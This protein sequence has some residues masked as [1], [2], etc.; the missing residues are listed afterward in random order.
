MTTLRLLAAAALLAAAGRAAA[1][2]DGPARDLSACYPAADPSRV[3]CY[4][5]PTP[6]GFLLGVPGT[7]AGLARDAVRPENLPWMAGIAVSTAGLLATDER[8]RAGAQ[9]IGRW[10]GISPDGKTA[11]LTSWFP[12]PYPTDVGSGLYYI[13]DGMVPVA[14]TLGMLGYGLWTSDTRVLQTTSHLAEGLVSVAIVVQT[15]KRTTGRQSPSRATE[16]GGRWSPFP[17]P[18]EY[19]K[20]VPGFDAFPSGHMATAMVAVTVLA[21][22]YP[23]YRYWTWSVGY[24]LMAL[25]GFQMMNNDVHWASDYPLAL[26]V[27]YGLGKHAAAR[28]RTEVRSAAPAEQASRRGRSPAVQVL[29]LPVDGG[30]GLAVRGAF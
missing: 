19:Q 1:Q 12:L 24:G 10:A 8:S 3:A 26:A 18:S 15:L 2:D 23:E 29:P 16:D 28:G 4:E 22:D 14:L 6:F 17:S 5:R 9:R 30:G 7:V 11:A 25:L 21:E 13:G 27:G 20:N